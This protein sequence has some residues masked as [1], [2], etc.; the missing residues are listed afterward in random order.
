MRCVGADQ[1]GTGTLAFNAVSAL[2]NSTDFG[3]NAVW[4][5]STARDLCQDFYNRCSAKDSI[6]TVKKGTCPSI[7]SSR[8]GSV[9]YNDETVF[10]LSEREYGLDSYSPISTSNSTT[11]KAECTQ[12]YNAAYSYYT[13][14]SRRVMYLGDANGNPTSSYA[15]QWERSRDYDRSSRVCIVNGGGSADYDYYNFSHG[16]A[17][18][19]VIG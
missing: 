7:N 17:P 19:F 1:D 14:N 2:P 11:S 5:G 15:Y 16:L 10:L 3:S 13:S 12:G 18:A 6:K 9:T 4:I 8:N